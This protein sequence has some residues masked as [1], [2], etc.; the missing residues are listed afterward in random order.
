MKK[1]LA[2]AAALMTVA[3]CLAGFS[4]A[5]ETAA[6]VK[7]GS[8]GETAIKEASEANKHLYIF[9]YSEDQDATGETHKAFEAVVGKMTDVAQAITL[10]K[11]APEEKALIK[12]FDL[13][14]APMPLVLVIAPNGAI[15]M[16]GVAQKMTEEKLRAG[17]ASPCQQKC[18]KALQDKKVVLLCAYDKNLAADDPTLKTVTDF[19]ADSRYTKTTEIVRVD[20][21]DNAEKKFL[22]QFNITAESGSTTVMLAPPRTLVKTFAGAVTKEGLE[23]AFK[24]ASAPG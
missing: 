10:K 13:K 14:N 3:I 23:G 9:F 2:P 22:K 18:L 21:A 7:K 12:K 5:E 17:I 15:T 6:E 16:G 24:A 4:R 8:P 19:K 1:T 11:D 20:P